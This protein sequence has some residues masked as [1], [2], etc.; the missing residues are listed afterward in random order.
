[1]IY[2]AAAGAQETKSQRRMRIPQSNETANCCGRFKPGKTRQQLNYSNKLLVTGKKKKTTHQCRRCRHHH[3][4]IWMWNAS[5]A[6]SVC[7]VKPKARGG[8]IT[9]M[10]QES[11]CVSGLWIL[12]QHVDCLLLGNQSG[13]LV[14]LT[15]LRRNKKNNLWWLLFNRRCHRRA[16]LF[17]QP[18]PDSS[19]S[20]VFSNASLS[21]VIPAIFVRAAFGPVSRDEGFTFIKKEKIQVGRLIPT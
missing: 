15:R 4:N 17:L 13:L 5:S 2:S 11:L 9:A 21:D 12:F 14:V 10:M 20:Y 6:C 3:L 16:I 18:V 1:M 8:F 7:K 19:R